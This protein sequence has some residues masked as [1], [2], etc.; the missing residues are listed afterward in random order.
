[1][2]CCINDLYDYDLIKKCRVCEN[3]SIKCN[4]NKNTKSKDD[5]QSQCKFCVNDYN[6]N[7]YNKNRDS[8]VE[9]RKI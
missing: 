9:H 2:S 6:K 5:L 8:E 3:I 1:M 4:F 7:Y